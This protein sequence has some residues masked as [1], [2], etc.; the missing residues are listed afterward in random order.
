MSINE[1]MMNA[2]SKQLY[3]KLKLIT[4]KYNETIT[5]EKCGIIEYFLYYMV[6]SYAIYG[7][8]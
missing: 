2:R 8:R 1:E 6:T 7:H 4:W 3:K 5:S